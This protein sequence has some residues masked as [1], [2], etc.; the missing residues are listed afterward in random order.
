M[1]DTLGES[2]KAI[3]ERDGATDSDLGAVLGKSED[4]A[5]AY[6]A[7]AADMG[8]VSFLRGCKEWDGCFANGVLGLVGMKL[9]PIEAES[10]DDQASVTTLLSFAMALSGELEKD[11]KVDDEDLERHQFVIERLG[12]IID[13]YR[14][15]IRSRLR[16]A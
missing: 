13:G 11:G 2:L 14:E 15:R 16:T 12:K 6:R 1:L 8:V 10:V 4:R 9:V 3:K 7:G 5:A